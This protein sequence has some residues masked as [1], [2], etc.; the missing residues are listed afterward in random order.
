VCWPVLVLFPVAAL[1]SQAFCHTMPDFVSKKKTKKHRTH[2]KL[3]ALTSF[4]IPFLLSACLLSLPHFECSSFTL[5]LLDTRPQPQFLQVRC[6]MLAVSTLHRQRTHIAPG[7]CP[8]LRLP[9]PPLSMLPRLPLTRCCCLLVALLS[10]FLRTCP[11]F[12]KCAAIAGWPGH[13]ACQFSLPC[14]MSTVQHRWH[15]FCLVLFPFRFRLLHS[16]R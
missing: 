10:L 9:S 15:R 12:R 13:S 2:T 3:T 8:S 7:P 5:R 11:C 1:S 14:P 4:H 6:L 16:S